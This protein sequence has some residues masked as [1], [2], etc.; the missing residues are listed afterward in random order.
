MKLGLCL[1]GGG[2]KGAAHI[3]VL[4][5][6][7]EEKIKIDYISGTSSG[8]IVA[9][10]YAVG[11]KPE[12]IYTLF[13]EYCKEIKYVEM[14][15]IFKLIYGIIFKRE[16]IIEGLSEGKNIEK[17]INK[18]CSEKNI[19]NIN[20]IKMPLL[21]PSVDLYTGKIYIF[22]SQN[23]RTTYSDEIKYIYDINIGKAV[24]ASCSYPGVFSPC[25]YNNT[26]LIDGGIRENVPWRETKINGADTVIS[27]VFEKNIKN[28]KK[29]NIIEVISN[30]IEI[31]S[32]E[33][34]NYEL[35]GADYLLK[36]KTKDIALLDFSKMEY[37][38]NIGYETTK[39]QINKIKQLIKEKDTA[40]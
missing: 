1:S 34:S 23:N 31:L 12:E 28:N 38:Y 37:L 29:D 39:K 15:N 25:K 33:L 19:A 13:Q 24:H 36:I 35:A 32:H 21:I 14:K 30:S 16:I 8:S 26:K 18:A 10:L 9:T 20:Q 17:I 5:A 40:L 2:A 6:L 22:S 11:Y 4:K 3:G 7:T 27:V